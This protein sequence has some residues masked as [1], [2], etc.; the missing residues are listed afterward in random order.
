MF[1]VI[2]PSMI[3]RHL[4]NVDFNSL[5]SV[6]DIIVRGDMDD[7]FHLRDYL[8]GNKSSRGNIQ[9]MCKKRLDDEFASIH[10]YWVWINFIEYINRENL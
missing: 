3:H 9:A 4:N 5:A 10:R 6:D 7:W 8:L 2:I 1:N